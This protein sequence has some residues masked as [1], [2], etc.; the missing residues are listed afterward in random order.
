MQMRM[1]NI[2]C[3]YLHREQ[4]TDM[5]INPLTFIAIFDD[6]INLTKDV[7]KAMTDI[8][9]KTAV[10]TVIEKHRILDLLNNCSEKRSIYSIPV[11][12]LSRTKISG[13]Q[14]QEVH[15]TE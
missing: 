15:P 2:I 8:F 5:A 10:L 13:I 11:K 12:S 9:N 7:A 4:D 6:A 3:V 1:L 14:I